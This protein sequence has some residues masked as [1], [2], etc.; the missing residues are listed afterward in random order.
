[1]VRFTFVAAIT[2]SVERWLAKYI[3]GYETYKAIAEEKL[4]SQAQRLS[5]T[6]ALVRQG[7]CWQ[8][9]YGVEH[10]DGGNYLV[11]LPNAPETVPDASYSP[12]AAK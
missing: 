4:H 2:K 5:Y 11:F 8:P 1:M 9:A 10:D 6:I 3:P 12:P 7:E